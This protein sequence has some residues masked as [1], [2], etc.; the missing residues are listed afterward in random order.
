MFEDTI[1]GTVV[2]GVLNPTLEE[3]ATAAEM[4]T[5]AFTSSAENTALTLGLTSTLV[6]VVL[7][8]LV[9]E[10]PTF[11]LALNPPMFACC[12]LDGGI[13]VTSFCGGRVTVVVLAA[14]TT[15]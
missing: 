8:A 7:V 14:A 11:S 4:P 12:A 1:A 15:V 13:C 9:I 3:T 6:L 5:G 2:R 10:I